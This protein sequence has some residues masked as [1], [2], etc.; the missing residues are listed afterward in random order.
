MGAES[1]GKQAHSIKLVIAQVIISSAPDAC[2]GSCCSQPPT[3]GS[4]STAS[5]GTGISRTNLARGSNTH[6][7]LF[8]QT[9]WTWRGRCLSSRRAGHVR[10]RRRL[11]LAQAPLHHSC[12]FWRIVTREHFATSRDTAGLHRKHE[13]AITS[14]RNTLALNSQSLPCCCS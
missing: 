7:Q 14:C 2:S 4:R 10:S 6:A 13:A 5:T 1:A 3:S 12:L 8:K 11:C 9:K